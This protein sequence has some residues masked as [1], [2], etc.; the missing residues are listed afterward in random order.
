MK[1]FVQKGETL[2]LTAPYNVNSGKGALIGST[3]F[4]VAVKDY[5]SGATDCEFVIE[6]V[7][8]MDKVS[9]QAWAV[10]D[11][12]YWDD[13]AK[14]C[15]TVKSTNI[16]VGVCVKVAANPTSTGRVLLTG[17]PSMDYGS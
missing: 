12:I 7:F 6:G 10:G 11:R 3:I 16:K 2:N 14:L 15:T 1:N 17:E 5:L 13:S 9:A 8:D 4:G